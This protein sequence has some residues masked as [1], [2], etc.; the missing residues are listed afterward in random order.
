MKRLSKIIPALAALL[1]FSASL[2]A[3]IHSPEAGAQ[4]GS[5]LDRVARIQREIEAEANKNRL[6]DDIRIS[7][8]NNWPNW[9]NW[10]N[11]NNNWNNWYNG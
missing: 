11:W 7:Q 5:V 6:L 1:G 9:P 10:N 2:D 4:T 3:D 8:W